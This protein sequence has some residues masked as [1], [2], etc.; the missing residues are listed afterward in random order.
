MLDATAYSSLDLYC[1][2]LVSTEVS[3]QLLTLFQRFSPLLC[4]L[5]WSFSSLQ[6]CHNHPSSLSVFD[7]YFF[8]ILHSIDSFSSSTANMA[9]GALAAWQQ[10]DRKCSVSQSRRPSPLAVTAGTKVKSADRKGEKKR[11]LNLPFSPENRIDTSAD[12]LK[13]GPDDKLGCR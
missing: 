7:S 2:R 9:T 12:L 10:G 8:I 11:L 4:I 5:I 3:F 1:I 13:D 6:N